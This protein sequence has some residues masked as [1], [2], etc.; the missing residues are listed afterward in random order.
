MDRDLTNV[1]LTAF[2]RV[3][4]TAVWVLG[5]AYPINDVAASPVTFAQLISEDT[6]TSHCRGGFDTSPRLRWKVS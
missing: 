2:H 4:S 6:D 1:Q 5:S 3:I